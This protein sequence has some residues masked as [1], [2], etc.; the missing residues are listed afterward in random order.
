MDGKN[1]EIVKTVCFK[2]KQWKCL[3]LFVNIPIFMYLLPNN[4]FINIFDWKI[5]DY[6]YNQSSQFSIILLKRL[7]I[8]IVYSHY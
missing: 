2:Q 6:V 4:I 7:H 1:D 5:C 8:I 3:K